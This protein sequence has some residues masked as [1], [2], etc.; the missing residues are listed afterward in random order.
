[1]ILII[2]GAHQGKSDFARSLCAD[3]NKILYNA[4]E[5]IKQLMHDKV[6]IAEFDNIL[7]GIEI[8]TCNE[9]GMGIVPLNEFDRQWRETTGR[10]MCR[11]AN[12]AD[13]VYRMVC[14]V[15]TRIKG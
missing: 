13:T 11:I 9:I 1:M 12:D 4:H 14:G 3:E 6:D 5:K 7:Q 10:I 2:G 8:V 15:P